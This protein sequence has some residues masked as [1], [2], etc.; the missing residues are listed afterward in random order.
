MRPPSPLS[1]SRRPP[2]R[3][4]ACS[5]T[6]VGARSTR[7]SL[8]Q[9]DCATIRRSRPCSDNDSAPAVIR[10]Q[11]HFRPL[12]AVVTSDG[13][14]LTS[15]QVMIAPC[16]G[17]VGAMKVATLVHTH[18]THHF[19]RPGNMFSPPCIGSMFEHRHRRP[20]L[21]RY[22][23]VLWRATPI[24]GGSQ[25]PEAWQLS[26]R[27]V[28]CDAPPKGSPGRA[29][30]PLQRWP[31]PCDGA[32][33]GQRW[34]NPCGPFAHSRLGRG[35]ARADYHKAKINSVR[36]CGGDADVLGAVVVQ[37]PITL[38]GTTSKRQH[39]KA[40]RRPLCKSQR[41][42]RQ[43]RRAR[44]VMRGDNQFVC[45]DL[46]TAARVYVQS[47]LCCVVSSTNNLD[48]ARLPR[49]LP[50]ACACVCSVVAHAVA[51]HRARGRVGKEATYG[52]QRARNGERL[53]N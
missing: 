12:A 20:A 19:K 4:C 37:R 8:V 27:T 11:H 24:G 40:G 1:L 9:H 16:S 31:T 15:P 51:M 18:V 45:V 5:V 41:R 43:W 38:Q 50:S 3:G 49:R 30:G 36:A 28:T 7:G 35:L 53:C 14:Q 22:A 34:W 26:R 48:S 17:H 46:Q 10:R 13:V 52:G 39:G 2:S 25:G 33:A 42:R 21:T 6:V 44:L 32:K 47:V 23:G 29:L